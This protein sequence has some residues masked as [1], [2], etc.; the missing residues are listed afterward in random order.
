MALNNPESPV[1]LNELVDIRDADASLFK[2]IIDQYLMDIPGH[3]EA[4]QKAQVQR[5]AEAIGQQA[6]FFRGSS[7]NFRANAFVDVCG[8]METQAHSGNLQ[9]MTVLMNEFTREL[10]RV[11]EALEAEQR[12]CAPGAEDV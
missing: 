8:R 1:D 6:H 9:N 12:K 3:V 2:S 11:R 4:L 10:Q 5:D 7:A